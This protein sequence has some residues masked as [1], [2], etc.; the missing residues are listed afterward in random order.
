MESLIAEFIQFSG[1][2]AKFLFRQGSLGTRLCVHS[3]WWF[4]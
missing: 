3:I 1:A 2:I 4:N